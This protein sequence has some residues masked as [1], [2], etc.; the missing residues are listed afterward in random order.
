[1]SCMDLFICSSDIW[2]HMLMS[3]L[4]PHFMICKPTACHLSACLLPRVDGRVSRISSCRL[5]FTAPSPGPPLPHPLTPPPLLHP[6]LPLAWRPHR[7]RTQ[8]KV[9]LLP[10]TPLFILSSLPLNSMSLF[11]HAPNF[12]LLF[13][14]SSLLLSKR[15]YPFLLNADLNNAL[16]LVVRLCPPCL[17]SPSLSSLLLLSD[18]DVSTQSHV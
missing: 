18:V 3:P 17:V 7:T 5:S 16:S 8:S 10:F 9:N 2:Y 1:M 13:S 15:A 14:S 4:M 11:L 6:Q 12:Y